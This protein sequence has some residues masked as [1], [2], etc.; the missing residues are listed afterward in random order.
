MKL[1]NG[2]R[3]VEMF[4]EFPPP[5]SAAKT[6]VRRKNNFDIKPN[7]IVADLETLPRGRWIAKAAS[8]INLADLC[9]NGWSEVPFDELKIQL[10]IPDLRHVR[11]APVP[12]L[13]TAAHRTGGITFVCQ[14][15]MELHRP[16]KI[17]D[18]GT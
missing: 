4:T 13:G 12:L 10:N 11:E 14:L 6:S 7:E 5:V 2:R 8:E 3:P 17:E 15:Q 9:A 1:N 16:L 18:R